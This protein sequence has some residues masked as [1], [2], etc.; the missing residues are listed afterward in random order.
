MR[1]MR[2]MRRSFVLFL[3]V[4]TVL[5]GATAVSCFG[6][7]RVTVSCGGE[8]VEPYEVF[9][10]SSAMDPITEGHSFSLSAKAE[11]VIADEEP[12][13]FPLIKREG[14]LSIKLPDDNYYA[15]GGMIYEKT[16]QGVEL[17][18]S[19]IDA[20]GVCELSSG[21]WYVVIYVHLGYVAVEGYRRELFAYV[22]RL[23]IE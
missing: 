17:R 6:R 20:S 7:N 3:C 12:E 4:A 1:A 21:E 2:A 13:C 19:F 5:T 15:E 23:E 14:E 9:L 8:S 22:F 11:R 10:Y 18:G 16:E